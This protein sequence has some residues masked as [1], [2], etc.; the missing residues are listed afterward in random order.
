VKQT[1]GVETGGGQERGEAGGDGLAAGGP[2]P[3]PQQ[4]QGMRMMLPESTPHPGHCVA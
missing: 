3:G 1:V 2:D 4:G